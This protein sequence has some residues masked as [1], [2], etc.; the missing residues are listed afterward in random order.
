MRGK[1][2][3]M[4]LAAMAVLLSGT[5]FVPM[6]FAGH[7]V[8]HQI[9][10]SENFTDIL[11]DKDGVYSAKWKESVTGNTNIQFSLSLGI[12]VTGNQAYPQSV[13][14]G[15]TATTGPDGYTPP[16]V[17]FGG[18]PGH[19]SFTFNAENSYST[20]TVQVN[21]IAPSL[22][23]AY[24]VKIAPTQI[25]GNNPKIE[26]TNGITISFTVIP[27][28]CT[29]AATSLSIQ[30]QS[31]CIIYKTPSATF[32]ATLVTTADSQPLAGQPIEFTIS[33]GSDPSVNLG[34][35]DTDENGQATLA[36]DTSSLGVG[37]YTVTASFQGSECY[38]AADPA[39]AALGVRYDFLGFQPPVLNVQPDGS[40]VPG[41]FSGMVIPVKV[42]IADYYGNSVPDATIYLTW[43]ATLADTTYA[44]IPAESVSAADTGN[45]MRYDP[46]ADQYIYNWD[47]SQLANGSYTLYADAG[48]GCQSDHTAV[49]ILQKSATRKKK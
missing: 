40:K 20:L 5:L 14:Y 6:A 49:V 8:T 7:H 39:V 25:E 29:P 24:T 41:L 42:K 22:A 21:I 12:R 10:P 32:T 31:S 35:V 48:E 11:S 44:D 9:S 19:N 45:K 37:G 33:K 43:S 18:N 15:V 23:G 26:D 46:E 28:G 27:S 3:W 13:T 17:Y 47:V 4:V 34:P 30:P 36:L 16:T 1:D 2:K 38:L